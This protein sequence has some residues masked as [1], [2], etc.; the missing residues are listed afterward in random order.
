[1]KVQDLIAQNVGASPDAINSLIQLQGLITHVDQLLA[2]LKSQV[3][4]QTNEG[5]QYLIN[6]YQ[7][8][9]INFYA[10]FDRSLKA[11]PNEPAEKY[12]YW[13]ERAIEKL[14]NYWNMLSPLLS[15]IQDPR[16]AKLRTLVREAAPGKRWID[17][18]SDDWRSRVPVYRKSGE[19]VDWESRWQDAII[20]IPYYGT[21]F[22]L[23]RFD[24]APYVFVTGVPLQDLETPWQWHV[25]WHEMAGQIVL[26][27]VKRKEIDKIVKA[28]TDLGQ[29]DE[30]RVMVE[31]AV[32][33][34]PSAAEPMT[35]S[36]ADVDRSGWMQEL[37]ED[38]YGVL[39]LGPS[40]LLAMK[41][42]FAR[43]YLGDIALF[44]T[45]HP[46]VKLRLD[47]AAALLQI[48]GF[49][50]TLTPDEA[51]AATS[52]QDVA[53]LVAKLLRDGY[54]GKEF[55]AR[56][57]AKAES[58]LQDEFVNGRPVG[59]VPTAALLAAARLAFDQKP[60]NGLDIA[61]AAYESLPAADEPY[62]ALP[63]PDDDFF[64]SL[65]ARSSWKELLHQA[66]HVYD[67]ATPRG[68]DSHPVTLS[69]TAHGESH[70]I[71]HT[72]ADHV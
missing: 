10:A 24:Y 16:M 39:S 1:M 42:V 50:D 40:M 15:G 52:L 41:Q 47:M 63:A 2:E 26:D 27:L 53:Q 61:R 34:R 32:N 31:S 19:R 4:N 29:W 45:R 5:I 57:D 6:C 71:R 12:A 8:F 23:L 48:M 70:S 28:A 64:E 68:H 66:F 38:A 65:V 59:G 62:V 60:A 58:G 30:W 51:T 72:T 36:F 35:I 33:S 9:A 69:W 20:T 37:V 11:D 22:E 25:V 43:Y 18:W 44:D 46:P 67:G 13:R 21:R 54:V 55:S 3:Q 17:H 7:Q 49:G 56:P 14:V